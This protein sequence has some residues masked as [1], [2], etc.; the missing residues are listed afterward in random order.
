MSDT[1]ATPIE[2]ATMAIE[3]VVQI[4]CPGTRCVSYLVSDGASAVLCLGGFY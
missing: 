1:S 2:Y 3:G 4:V